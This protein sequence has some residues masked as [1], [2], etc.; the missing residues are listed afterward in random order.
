M[1]QT[2]RWYGPNDPVSL[3]DIMQAGATGIVTALHEVPVGEVWSVQAI[4]DRQHIIAASPDGSPTRLRWSV[5]ESVPVSESIKTGSGDVRQHLEVFKQC[6]RNL[7]A[8]G[9]QTVC[10][11]FMPVLD[12]TRTDLDFRMPDGSTALRFNADAFAAFEL[13]ILHRPGAEE[14]YSQEQ[15]EKARAYADSL[16]DEVKLVLQ[17]NII[18]GLPGSD[19]DY[20]LSAFQA[21]LDTYRHIDEDGLRQNLQRF[22][23]EVIPVAEK[24]GVRMAIHPDDPPRPLLGLPRIVSTEADASRLLHM[25]DSPANGL[26]FCTGS[27]GVRPDNNLPACSGD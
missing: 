6:I 16:S 20:T 12:W 9:I 2:W 17:R 4:K 21:V 23:E 24:A 5:V 18:A 13:H 15:R 11:N 10:Y 7:G 19:K 25:A 26:T 22:L 14:T 27:Y 8:C 1:E 3:P